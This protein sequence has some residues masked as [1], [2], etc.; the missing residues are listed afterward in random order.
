MAVFAH[1]SPGDSPW[2]RH[3]RRDQDEQRDR[4]PGA[5]QRRREPARDWATRIRSGRSPIASTTA[6]A[7][8]CNPARRRRTADPPLQRRDRA[9]RAAED[10]VPVPGVRAG[11]RDEN[12]GGHRRVLTVSADG[13]H[14][15]PSV[16]AG[17]GPTLRRPTT[18]GDDDEHDRSRRRTAAALGRTLTNQIQQINT[19]M[20]TV[21]GALGNTLWKGPAWDRFEADWSGSFV[22][23]CD[24]HAILVNAGRAE[25]FVEDHVAT[26]RPS[27]T[28][29]ALA[30]IST[31][32]SIRSR[33]S[34]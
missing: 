17:P 32:R 19:V 26:L 28:L 34:L 25:R 4:H 6:S 5:D 33:A 1:Q 8:S 12:V 11:A 30:R 3:H 24:R 18:E 21:S 31:P 13:S 16:P 22:N 23:L 20:S 14:L 29:T 27:V 2:P 15:G 7:Y 9:R 10:E